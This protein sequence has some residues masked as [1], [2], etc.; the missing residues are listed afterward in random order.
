MHWPTHDFEAIARGNSAKSGRVPVSN[1]VAVC[2]LGLVIADLQYSFYAPPILLSTSRLLLPPEMGRAMQS[3]EPPMMVAGAKP[4]SKKWKD[5]LD[6]SRRKT[7]ELYENADDVGRTPHAGAIRTTLA[8][9]GASAVFCVQGVPTVVILAVGEYNRIAIVK[10]H[11]ALWNQGL[12]SVLLVLTGDTVR[13]FSLARIPQSGENDDFDNRCLIR[14]LNAVA[15]ALALQEVIY[16]AESGRLWQQHADYFR[17]EERIDHVLLDNLTASHQMLCNKGLSP[18]AAQALLIQAM[19]IAY[20]ED[21][22]VTGRKYFLAASNGTAETFLTLLQS[23]NP[24]TLYR[25]FKSLRE[26][27][28]GDLFVAP[29]SFD[30]KGPRPRLTPPHLKILADFRSGRQEMGS[31]AKQFRFWGYD[32]KYIPIELISAVYDRFL[33]EK[34]DLRRERGAYYTPMFLAD[35]VISQ[36]WDTL[37]P[38]TKDKGSFLDPACGSG[39][40]LVRC[41]Q[42]LCEHW[43]ET[44]KSRTI[45]WDSLLTILSRLR[46]WDLNSGAVRVAV[47]SLYIALLEEV[48]PPDIRLLIRRGKLLPELWDRTL[49][50]QDFFAVPPGDL[51]PDVV[52]GNPP[53][54]SRRGPERSSVKWCDAN[55][56]PVPGG[57]DAWAFV[58]KSLQHLPEHGIVAFLLPAMGFLHNHADKAVAARDRF[59]REARIFHI[60]NFADLRFQLFDG[61]VRPAALIIFGRGAQHALGYR[62]H[63]WVPKA[64]L[65]L[66]TKRLITL[67]SVD[68]CL[69][70]SRMAEEDPLV[71]KRRLWMNDPEAKLFKYLTVLPQLGALVSE[72]GDLNRRKRPLGNRW[73]IGQGFKPANINR[74]GD[75]AYQREESETVATTPYLPITAFRTLAQDSDGLHPWRNGTVHRKGFEGGFRGPRVLVPRGIDT[76]QWRL[77]AAYSE[78]RLTFQDIVQAIVVP[79]GNEQRAKLLTALLNSRLFLWFAFHGTASFGSDRPEVKQAELLRLPFP[80]PT[81]LPERQRAESAA[82][83]LVSLVDE[84]AK[85]VA[86]PFKLESDDVCVFRDLDRLT[87]KYFCLSNDEITLVDDTVNN[88]IPAI[89]PSQ[90]SFPDLWKPADRKDREDYATTLVRS[91]AQWFDR[92]SAIQIL[93]EARSSDLAVLRLILEGGRTTTSYVEKNDRSVGEVLTDLFTHIHQPLPG[94]FR[95]M[96]DFRLFIDNSLYLVKPVQRR[97][98]LRSTAL[99]DADAIALDLHDAAGFGKG[100]SHA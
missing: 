46:G 93:L 84:A 17:P 8:E 9:L 85:S 56:F 71:F 18:D 37:S 60:V 33:S 10:L 98:W 86:R 88:I 1:A 6:L 35:T 94:N 26:D 11:A 16:G 24:S 45:R 74:L 73:V 30:M 68:K 99:A 90:G 75:S 57:E 34:K 66:R 19:F 58:W 72:Y 3:G 70:T 29:C 43:R 67:S 91:M 81:D 65:N 40:F 25:L 14:K 55:H 95:L 100:G 42:R 23:A 80:S 83:G 38:A 79:P 41:F 47:F 12:A 22:E 36:V 5:C 77:R 53:W 44:R 54:S 21:R 52:L 27:F 50:P 39:V 15:D 32:F 96:P 61:A 78:E 97:F 28:N 89:Q 2:P 63:Y 48:S 69:L 62:F 82:S 49:C 20:L 87:Y 31:G 13:A 51:R 59:I 4:L 64:D 76:K 7:P 92:D